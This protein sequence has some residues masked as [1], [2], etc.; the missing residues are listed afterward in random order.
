VADK[1]TILV[2][3]SATEENRYVAEALALRGEY[4]VSFASRPGAGLA[5]FKKTSFDVVVTDLDFP[6]INSTQLIRE[7]KEVDRHCVIIVLTPTHHE[8]QA[9]EL[10]VYECIKSPIDEN[11][12]F[13]FVRKGIEQHDMSASFDRV[14]SGL[15]ERNLALEKQA[16]FLTNRLEE[17]TKNL[18]RL[19]ENLRTNYLHTI[20]V[21]AQAIDARDHYTHSHS[22]NVVKYACLIAREMGLSARE[23]ETVSDACELHD[24]GKIGIE[25]QILGKVQKL[26]D[27]EWK[28]I[29]RHPVIGAQILEPLSFMNEVI[30]LIRLHHEHYDGSGYPEGRKA[31]DIPLGARIIH[32]ADA[33]EAMTSERAYRRTPLTKQQ[34]IDEIK[35]FSGT[36]FDPKVVDAFLRVVDTF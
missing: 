24:L 27:D 6:D 11:E 8:N 28:Q 15:K 10:G 23:V 7:L 22:Q 5:L 4:I 33:Y 30:E 14:I 32:L 13:L 35:N 3:C 21:L 20:K 25:D 26:T 36:Q 18:S 9:S 1:K 12:L 2:L 29:R 19:Y 34:A 31:E 16:V 17:S